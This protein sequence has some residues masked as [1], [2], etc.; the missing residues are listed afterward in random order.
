[1]LFDNKFIFFEKSFNNFF[2][3]NVLDTNNIKIYYVKFKD[4]SSDLPLRYNT[5]LFDL[6]IFDLYFL[7][8]T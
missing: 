1:L 3:N 4:F 7:I 8:K 2:S 6:N 5:N